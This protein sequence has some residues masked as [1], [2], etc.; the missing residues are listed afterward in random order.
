MKNIQVLH[1]LPTSKLSKTD[2]L[3]LANLEI[4]TSNQV[5]ILDSKIDQPYTHETNRR[6]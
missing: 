1:S 4:I 5:V 6:D 3:G 2:Y